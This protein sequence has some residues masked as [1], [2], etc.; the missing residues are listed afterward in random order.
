[1]NRLKHITVSEQNYENLRRLGNTPDSFN[2]I[3]SR[4]LKERE[5]LES[6]SRV[7]TRKQT[8]TRMTHRGLTY[9]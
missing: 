1:M 6:E 4:I 8:L 2:T 3:I 5:M 9:E 7:A